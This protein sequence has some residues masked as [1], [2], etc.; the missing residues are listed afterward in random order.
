MKGWKIAHQ[1]ICLNP[2]VSMAGFVY[3]KD[4]SLKALKGGDFI[5]GWIYFER[6]HNERAAGRVPSLLSACLKDVFTGCPGLLL[7]QN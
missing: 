4:C 6:R 7:M 1:F 5:V 2:F 3:M